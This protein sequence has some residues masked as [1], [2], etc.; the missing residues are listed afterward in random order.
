M[1]VQLRARFA[2]VAKVAPRSYWFVFG[3]TLINRLG[4]FVVPLLTIYLTKVR[5]ISVAEAGLVVSLFGGGSI[6][7]SFIGGQLSDHWGRRPTLLAS[8][9]GGALV[10]LAL[11]WARDVV[12][13]AALVGAL[14]VV[15]EMYR[16]SVAAFVADVIPQELR[17]EAFGLFYW[18][19]NVGFAFAAMIGGLVADY[20]FSYLFIADAATMAIY[21]LIVAFAVPETRPQRRAHSADDRPANESPWRDRTYMIYMVIGFALILLPMQAGSALSAHMTWQGFASSTYGIV[22]GINGVLIVVIQPIV[23]GWLGK[24]DPNRVLVVAAA[25]YGIGISA[26]GFATFAVGHAIA[27]AIW[28]MA[29]ILESPTRASMISAMAPVHARG[30]YQSVNVMTWSAAQLVGPPLGNFVWDRAS[31]T[32]LWL[33]CLGVGAAVAFA[34]ATTSSARRERLAQ[35]TSRA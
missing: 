8:L 5:G 16:P 27:V 33:G 24:R 18:A 7:G 17:A 20:D 11:G 1:L 32:T 2:S 30:R 12:A 9:F 28:T 34:Y 35:A 21:G 26:H 19:V 31:P 3:G 14:G 13:I 15:G 29:E 25:L 6:I 4:G 22:M 23:L 10:M